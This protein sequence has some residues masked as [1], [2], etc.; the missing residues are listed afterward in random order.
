LGPLA[1]RNHTGDDFMV[2]LFNGNIEHARGLGTERYLTN[3]LS[4][5]DREL[6]T[7]YIRGELNGRPLDGNFVLRVWDENGVN[8][9]AIE[10]VQLYLKYRYWTRF[11]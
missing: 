3:P 10:D 5:T 7:P 11:D 1:V 2:K 8:F 6:L 9:N 4:T